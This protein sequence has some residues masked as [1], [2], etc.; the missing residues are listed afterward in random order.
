[1]L[2]RV[3]TSAARPAARLELRAALREILARWSGLPD[4]DL[5]LRETRCGPA[6]QGKLQGQT[7]DISLSYAGGEGWI[8]LLR[9]LWIGVD[10]MRAEP[11]PDIADVARHYL[12]PLLEPALSTAAFAAAWTE[13]EARLKCL[14]RDLTEW[15]PAQ[16]RIES[17][18]VVQRLM[19][20]NGLIGAVAV[21][22]RA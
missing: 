9:S 17:A 8:G 3:R 15:S 16:A 21:A 18:C 2:V 11:M 1:V 22:P 20:E 10:V 5:P 14:K 12:G 19:F 13:R 4:S 7:L 6:W